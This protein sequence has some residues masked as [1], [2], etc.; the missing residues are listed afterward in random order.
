MSLKS[1]SDLAYKGVLHILERTVDIGD[2]YALS[3]ST[4]VLWFCS[5][6]C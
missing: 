1:T 3:K 5:G 4:V 2:A 6:L